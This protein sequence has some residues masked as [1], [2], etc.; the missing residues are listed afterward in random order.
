MSGH[1]VRVDDD[2]YRRLRELAEAE[3]ET[4]GGIVARAIDA[5]QRDRYWEKF[6]AAYAALVA[7]PKAWREELEERAAWNVTLADDLENDPY[8]LNDE[9]VKA[10]RRSR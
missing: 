1:M 7:D 8:P 10:I 5:Y 2:A 4:I 3:H 6:N 9:D